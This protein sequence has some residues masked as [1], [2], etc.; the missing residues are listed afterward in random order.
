MAA[1]AL[2][3]CVARSSAAVVLTMHDKQVFVFHKEGVQAHSPSLQKYYKIQRISFLNK[4]YSAQYGLTNN[5]EI[6]AKKFMYS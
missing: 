4:I 2:A 1:D 5:T 6:D 3:P